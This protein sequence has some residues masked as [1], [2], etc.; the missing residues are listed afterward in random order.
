MLGRKTMPFA[1]RYIYM[2]NKE[3]V[4]VILKEIE[5]EWFGGFADS[6]KIKCIHSL[7]DMAKKQ[8]IEKILEISSK[9][10][11]NLGKKLSAFNL[12]IKNK[13]G[14]IATVETIFQGSK[15][16]A[17]GDGPYQDLYYKSSMEAKQDERIKRSDISYFMYGKTRFEN[18]PRTFF[19]DYVYINCL[20]KNPQIHSELI[21]F[22][23]FSDIA[24]NP[25]KSVN[26]QAYS[27]AL[28][29]SLYLQ[30]YTKQDLTNK[31]VFYDLTKQEYEKRDIELSY[32][33]RLI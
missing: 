1:K 21:K 30:G 4:G 7:H 16:F 17:N 14:K 28:F 18:K 33:D 22:A 23:G 9:S 11:I 20:N 12:E 19:Y 10:E 5:F 3:S 15:V 2:P 26:C 24:F 27:V 13:T 25:K 8:G 31:S 32:L 29:V 6:Q